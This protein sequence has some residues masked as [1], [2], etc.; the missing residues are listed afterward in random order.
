MAKQKVLFSTVDNFPVAIDIEYTN[1]ADK[2]QKIFAHK[3]Y[4]DSHKAQDFMGRYN[5]Y[6][7]NT[8]SP[9]LNNDEKNIFKDVDSDN[10]NFLFNG[11]VKCSLIKDRAGFS[12]ELAQNNYPP[13]IAN[14]SNTIHFDCSFPD[15]D[16][17]ELIKNLGF[18]LKPNDIVYSIAYNSV[19]NRYETT[20]S[21][22]RGRAKVNPTKRSIMWMRNHFS[23][24]ASEQSKISVML[25]GYNIARNQNPNLDILEYANNLNAPAKDKAL[26]SFYAEEYRILQYRKLS[27]FHELKH[28]KNIV[29]ENGLA[30]KK[31]FKRLT[32]ENVYRLQV[33]DERSAYLS[34]AVNA[35][36]QYLQ[37]G[38]LNNLSFFDN[39][40][41]GIKNKLMSLP[42]NQRVAY[43]TNMPEIMKES[44]AAFERNHRANYD[45]TQFKTNMPIAVNNL[46]VSAPEDTNGEEFKRIQSL[47]YHFEVYNPTTNRMEYKNLS[48][49]L[50]ASNQVRITPNN[51]NNIIYPELA[52][53]TSRLQSYQSDV[54]A[55]KIDP[56]LV[57]EARKLLRDNL[58]NPRF[59]NEVDSINI[60]NLGNNFPQPSPN[61]PAIP[62]NNAGWSDDL[63]QYWSHFNG[64]QELAK[65]NN[66]YS[67]KL[68]NDSISYSSPKDVSLSENA[69]YATYVKLVQ[70]PTNLH[71][72]VNFQDSLSEEQALLLYVACV[73]NGRKVKGKIPTDLSK[74]SRLNLSPTVLNQFNANVVNYVEDVRS[75]NNSQTIDKIRNKIDNKENVSHSVPTQNLPNNRLSKAGIVARNE[76][77]R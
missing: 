51:Y 31:D 73:T 49:Y 17:P 52:N 66:E 38:D 45:H 58:R 62:T 34:Q 75:E 14:L 71:R 36:N 48:Q 68:N 67:F 25:N 29:L 28:V 3:N 43:A 20:P 56:Q 44:F 18:S 54:Q 30:L 26:Y 15:S 69:E 9:L 4:F 16:I 19:S 13:Q 70:E 41:I 60:S 24:T 77:L 63:K 64:Y 1:A 37:N 72:E 55:G 6:S 23:C 32:L 22:N 5:L 74:I 57:D 7:Q 2:A 50:N 12:N 61:Q 39:E 65:N 21:F 47:Y 11:L 42:V 46:P 33:E 53:L 27:L 35:L 40:C 59:I 76:K 10:T 8:N